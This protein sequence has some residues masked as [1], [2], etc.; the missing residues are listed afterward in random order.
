MIFNL[1]SYPRNTITRKELVLRVDEMMKNEK[2]KKILSRMEN[3]FIGQKSI[4]TFFL[5]SFP[6]HL[7][8]RVCCIG[9]KHNRI[10]SAR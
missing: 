10:V 7:A 5:I 1:H 8:T 3:S 9:R 6:V 2:K 4:E